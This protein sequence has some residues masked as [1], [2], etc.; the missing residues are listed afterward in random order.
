[1]SEILT[2]AQRRKKHPCYMKPYINDVR[3]L[4]QRED[5]CK[6]A[7][8]QGNIPPE[9]ANNYLL[10]I[11]ATYDR[12]REEL[13]KYLENLDIELEED[14]L[15]L[16]YLIDEKTK[17]R[18]RKAFR[19]EEFYKLYK[20]YNDICSKLDDKLVDINHPEKVDE[21]G[22]DLDTLMKY[23]QEYEDSTRDI[24]EYIRVVRRDDRKVMGTCKR[25]LK[26]SNLRNSRFRQGKNK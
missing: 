23:R 16:H 21:E 13:G 17:E 7:N 24:C 15:T 10:T 12:F 2:P 19:D 18:F 5:K 25:H 8:H 20:R 1:M 9:S 22:H 6:D 26:G 14:E 3:Y 11:E 4:D